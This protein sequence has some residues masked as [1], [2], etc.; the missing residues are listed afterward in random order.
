MREIYLNGEFLPENEAKISVFDRGFLMADAVYEGIAILDGK[1]CNFP[2]HMTRLKRSLSE[3]RFEFDPEGFDFLGVLRELVARNQVSEGFIYL[4]ITR[5][6]QERDFVI[7]K[8][9]KPTILAFT[10]AKT[11]A[12]PDN[13]EGGISIVT[14]E[15]MRWRRCDVKTTQLLWASLMKTEAKAAGADDVWLTRDGMVLEGSSNNAYIVKDDKIIT[16]P[17]STEILPG[18]T[19]KVLLE[20]CSKGNIELEERHFT[21]EEAEQADEAFVTAASTWV[22]PVTNINGRIISNGKQ[23]PVA[24]MLHELYVRN[25]RET[26][27]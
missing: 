26:A 12:F 5:G 25:A 2:S 18:I 16:R 14:R 13:L 24:A 1:I 3:M 6:I 20:L 10:Q 19:R 22:M 15:D 7:Q 27:I 17:N 8:G 4:Q 23:G 9:L 11:N 21:I